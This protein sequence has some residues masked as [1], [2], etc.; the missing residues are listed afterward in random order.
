MRD[1][2]SRYWSSA[3]E[4][5]YGFSEYD[6]SL[7]NFVA[8]E[9][10]KGGK[11]LEVA[12][13]TGYPFG[14]FFQK[15]G[16]SVYGV[17]ISP[18][19]IEKCRL[20]NPEICCKVGDAEDLDFPDNGFDCTYCFHATW[21]FPN[22]GK[23]I[24]EMIRVT[25]PGGLVVFDIQN[26][27]NWEIAAALRKQQFMNNTILGRS[28]SF[29]KMVIKHAIGRGKPSLHFVLYEVPSYP[30]EIYNHLRETE[31]SDIQVMVR[32]EDDSIERVAKRDS[33]K[34]F[35]RVVFAARKKVI[36]FHRAGG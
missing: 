1:V 17:D 22:L 19:L 13:G 16:Y 7:V 34:E 23:A 26:R 3:R 25:K 10:V 6:K 31:A 35:A 27:N 32:K 36:D 9:V 5:I 28:L 11:I 2:Y 20:L 33:L 15:A 29:G 21:Y 14:D 24:D 30:E 12:I 8:G 18:A 4:E